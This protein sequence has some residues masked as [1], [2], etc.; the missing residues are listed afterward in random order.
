MP[1]HEQVDGQI[2]ENQLLNL[3]LNALSGVFGVSFGENTDIED[4]Y[5]D[6]DL[7]TLRAEWGQLICHQ[8]LSHPSRKFDLETVKT[9]GNTPLQDFTLSVLRVQV[10]IVVDLYSCPYCDDK[11]ETNDLYY[12]EI[13]DGTTALQAYAT[14]YP[15]SQQALHASA[16]AVGET[17]HCQQCSPGVS[18]PRRQF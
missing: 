15:S 12:N 11:D 3:L 18:R 7:H 14:M 10:E 4:I 17:T 1:K 13:K 9:V 2:H 5:E 8:H 6:L 16:V